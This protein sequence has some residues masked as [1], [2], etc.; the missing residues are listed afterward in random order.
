LHNYIQVYENWIKYDKQTILVYP[1]E[2][3]SIYNRVVQK[4]YNVIWKLYKSCIILYEDMQTVSGDEPTL[5][6]MYQILYNVIWKTLT[7]FPFGWAGE[8]CELVRCVGQSARN[9]DENEK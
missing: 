6:K 5:K 3:V 9:E 8:Q 4:L 7:K 2:D 1:F